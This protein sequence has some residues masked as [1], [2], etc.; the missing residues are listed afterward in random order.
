MKLISV[1]VLFIGLLSLA[2]TSCI[3]RDLKTPLT[4]NKGTWFQL[5]TDD[6]QIL[7]TVEAEGVIKNVLFVASWGGDGFKTLEEKA[8]KK[9]GDE[10]INYSFDIEQYGIFIFYNTYTWKARGTVIKY[11]DKA[12]K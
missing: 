12:I 9:G 2:T 5:T 1:K 6:F 7:G 11:R 3:Y 8:K 10:I 4:V